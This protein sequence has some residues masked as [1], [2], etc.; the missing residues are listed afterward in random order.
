MILSHVYTAVFGATGGPEVGLFK[1][2]QKSWPNIKQA[3]YSP[4]DDKLFIGNMGNL[5]KEMVAFYTEAIGHQQPRE[6][7]LELL[8]LCLIFLGG[9]SFKMDFQFRA[10]G[11]MHHARWMSKAIYAVKII[12][13][14]SQFKLTVKEKRGLT[15]LSL[16]VALVYGR[17][18]HE[19]PL[20]SHA[21]LNDAH[22][23][24]L[25]QGYPNQVIAEAAFTA[26]FRHLWFFSEHLV[27]LAFFDNRVDLDVKR[28]MV[29]NLQLPK[30][31][32]ALKKVNASGSDSNRLET[33]VTKRTNDLFCC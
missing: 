9:G 8:R 2:F 23:I 1:R 29:A 26:I 5:R 19:A 28:A 30:N 25:F 7:Y 20:P 15:E 16:F 13:F 4:A 32:T 6:D 33:F 31:K 12:L 24:T 21:P 10:P 14:Q 17:F 11:A 18:W 3:E 27:G 22:M